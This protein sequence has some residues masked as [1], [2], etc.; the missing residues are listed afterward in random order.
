MPRLVGF[1]LGFSGL[2]SGWEKRRPG[3]GGSASLTD[4]DIRI[5]LILYPVKP[6]KA[7]K[8]TSTRQIMVLRLHP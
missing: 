2:L 7:S 8:M 1:R 4:Y 5:T 6:A 3:M